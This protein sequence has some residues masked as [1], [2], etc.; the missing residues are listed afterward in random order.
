[1]DV[2]SF[3]DNIEY[4]L[5]QVAQRSRYYQFIVMAGLEAL[6]LSASKVHFI[7][8]SSYSFNKD[9]IIDQWK[10]CTLVPQ[11]AVRDAWDRSYNPG[12]L[13]PMLCPGLPALAEE[14]LQID[15]VL[16]G[17]DQVGVPA[18]DPYVGMRWVTG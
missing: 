14:H 8:E 13:S 17:T 15:F 3:L 18:Q 5:E 11:Q 12:I 1:M 16:G 7:E 6:G 2:Y 10:L 9:F 4:P